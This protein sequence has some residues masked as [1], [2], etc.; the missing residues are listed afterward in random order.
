MVTKETLSKQD[1]AE[2]LTAL[3][4]LTHSVASTQGG[5]HLEGDAQLGLVMIVEK[6]EG[7]AKQLAKA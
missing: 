7:L 1:A 2:K 5:L 3:L 4:A 6:M